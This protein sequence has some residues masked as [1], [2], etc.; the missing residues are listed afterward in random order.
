MKLSTYDNKYEQRST[1]KSQAL[2]DFVTD[3]NDGIQPEAELERKELH[4]EET[5]GRW[6]IFTD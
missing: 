1:I 2:V 4:K 6:T 3:F 5:I